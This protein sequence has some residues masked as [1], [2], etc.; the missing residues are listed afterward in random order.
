V[1]AKPSVTSE[2]VPPQYSLEIS[3]VESDIDELGHASNIAYVRWIQDVA[4][5]HSS[6]VG[7][8]IDAYRKLGGLFFVR[9]H[10]IDYMRPVLRGDCLQVRTWISSASAAKCQ[11][12]TEIV[13]DSGTVVMKAV[14]TWGFV[15]VSTGRPVRIPESIRVA[16]GRPSVTTRV[17]E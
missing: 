16:F 8:D 15:D 6:A 10:E 7:L 14:T 5:A 3:V 9:R 12:A 11:R 1:S 13:N 2:F 4:I 17:T